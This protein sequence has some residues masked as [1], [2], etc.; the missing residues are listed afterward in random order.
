EL[1]EK[2]KDPGTNP[3]L[4]TMEKFFQE[5]EKIDPDTVLS[6][7]KILSHFA[8]C[9]VINRVQTPSDANVGKV[10]QGMMQQYVSI[11][12]LVL[13]ALPEDP[14]VKKSINR[15]KPIVIED[16]ESGFSRALKQLAE[17]L[18]D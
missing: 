11:K 2:A 1:L 6:T 8:P 15:L 9:I 14:A 7:Q 4:N 13:T 16:P 17:E 5:A 18:T 3:H 10:L 12:S